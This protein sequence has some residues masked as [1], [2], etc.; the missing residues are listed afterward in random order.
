MKG[1]IV[2]AG[3]GTRFLPV[4]KTIPKE[5][6]PLLN[7]PSIAFVIEEFLASGIDDII[8]ISSRRKHALEDYLD[9]ESELEALFRAEGEKSAEKLELI[10]PYNAHF[11]FVRQTAMLGTGHALLQIKPIVAGEPVVVAYPDD[12]HVGDVPLTRQLIETYEKTGC[13]VLAS[14]YEK[15]H[16]DRYGVLDLAADGLHVKGIIE[17]PV[18]GT[19]PSHEASMGRYLY[20]PE[21]FDHLEE[22]WRRHVERGSGGEYFHVYALEQLMKADKVVF[23]RMEGERLDTG[24]LPGFFEATL[25]YAKQFPELRAILKREAEG[26]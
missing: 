4:T 26:L 25:R 18:E 21:F 9:R 16:L 6:L 23:R 14:F 5:M 8:I 3:Y 1:V 17:K 20:I 7:K 10:R 24:A 13:S 19:A 22:G 15:D 12:L 2:A 11:S